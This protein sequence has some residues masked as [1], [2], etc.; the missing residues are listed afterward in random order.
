[1]ALAAAASCLTF[2]PAANP[3]PPTAPTRPPDYWDYESLNVSWNDQEGYEVVRKVGR[4]KYSEVFEVRAAVAA[5]H[6]WWWYTVL[7]PHAACVG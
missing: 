5:A 2:F 6:A 4:G 7:Q 3:P 1:L